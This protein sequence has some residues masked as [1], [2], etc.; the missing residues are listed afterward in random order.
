IPIIPISFFIGIL[1]LPG[2]IRVVVLWSLGF[3]RMAIFFFKRIVAK[4][5]SSPMLHAELGMMYEKIGLEEQAR[6]EYKIAMKLVESKRKSLEF[7]DRG[8]EK[9]G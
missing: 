1:I 6:V 7:I 4:N 8:K 9:G 5:P 2:R 3:K